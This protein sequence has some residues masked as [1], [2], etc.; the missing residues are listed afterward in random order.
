MHLIFSFWTASSQADPLFPKSAFPS[1][2]L[3]LPAINICIMDSGPNHKPCV[4]NFCWREKLFLSVTPWGSLRCLFLSSRY[5]SCVCMCPAALLLLQAELRQCLWTES[6]TKMFLPALCLLQTGAGRN[7]GASGLG[8]APQP[9]GLC[10]LCC[11][12]RP[13]G[14][15]ALN[16]GV[17]I[18]IKNWRLFLKWYLWWIWPHYLRGASPWSVLS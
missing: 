6:W 14:A 7:S 9:W 2:Q 10:V 15:D 11:Q 1:A 12:V 5:W 3:L 8:A 13:H 16:L 4:E 18:Q 17:Q